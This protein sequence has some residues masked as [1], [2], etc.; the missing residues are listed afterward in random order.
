MAHLT[1]YLH[2]Y[3]ALHK[4]WDATDIVQTNPIRIARWQVHPSYTIAP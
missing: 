3:I 4:P 2:M 1:D